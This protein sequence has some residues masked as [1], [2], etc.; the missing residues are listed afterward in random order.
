M[1]AQGFR[2]RFLII[3][4]LLFIAASCVF[5]Q[6]CTIHAEDAAGLWG[7]ADGTGCGNDIVKAAF[8]ASGVEVS[9]VTTPYN[10]AKTFVMEG[11]ALAC[12]GMGRVD[13]ALIQLDS[14]KS[15]AYVMKAAGVSDRIEVAFSLGVTR[16]Y[17]RFAVDNPDTPA[18]IK[19]FDEG[20]VKIKADGTLDKIIAFWKSKL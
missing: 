2:Y 3:S 12:F 9:L 10:R 8:R 11:K 19:A 1:A 13:V 5:A 18:A 16:T 14:L 7:Q 17:L 15:A 20:M 4:A 6:T